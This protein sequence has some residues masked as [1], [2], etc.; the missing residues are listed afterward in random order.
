MPTFA[1]SMQRAIVSASLRQ[2]MRIVSCTSSLMSWE[3]NSVQE[4]LAST[5]FSPRASLRRLGCRQGRGDRLVGRSE[6][7]KIQMEARRPRI[8]GVSHLIQQ[9]G[10]ETFQPLLNGLVVFFQSGILN[11]NMAD[12]PHAH[13]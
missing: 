9:R 1:F 6:T 10:V 4:V 3:I 5:G 8:G 13:L 11:D 7:G 12:A 2:G